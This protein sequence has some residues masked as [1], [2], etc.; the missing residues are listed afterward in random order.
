MTEKTKNY[1]KEQEAQLRAGYNPD[2]TEEQRT[3]QIKAL[4]GALGRNVASI[5]AKLTHM[6][7]YIKK[8]YAT[9][10]G[11]KPELKEKIVEDIARS[12]GLLNAETVESLVKAT[13]K[14]LQLVRDALLVEP[15]EEEQEPETE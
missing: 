2:A 6:G 12:L 10:K 5:R 3:A 9:K 8:V 14:A 13:K 15:E 11:E 1:S 4:A 7:L